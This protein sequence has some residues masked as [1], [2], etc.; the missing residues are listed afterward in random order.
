MEKKSYLVTL[1]PKNEQLK[2]VIAYFYFHVCENENHSES[3]QFY[4]NY[5]HAITI[6]FGNKVTLNSNPIGSKIDKSENPNEI[7]CLYTINT[8]QKI[9][10]EMNGA[11]QKIGIVFYPL[12]VNHFIKKPLNEIMSENFKRID[13]DETFT[14]ALQNINKADDLEKQAS[15]LENALLKLYKPLN[16]EILNN[17]IKEI[18]LSNGAIKIT[19]LEELFKI[20]RKTLLRLFK[21]HT[22]TSV[23]DY[24]KMVMFRNSLNYAIQNKNEANL[25]DVALYAMYYDQ[26]HFIKHFKSITNE[27]PKTLLPKINKLGNEDLYWHF[28]EK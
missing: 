26:S 7:T 9:Q 17:S 27:T 11:Y 1:K 12:G 5:L 3:F 21:K 16:E 24:K 15:I 19:E 8:T 23:E 20:N 14:E 25:T 13:L 10:V 4:P 2:K 22:L 6:Y 18:I 28:F